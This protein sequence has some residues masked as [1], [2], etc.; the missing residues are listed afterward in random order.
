MQSEIVKWL[1]QKTELFSPLSCLQ[2]NYA[3][4]T[5]KT[6]KNTGLKSK[7][8]VFELKGHLSSNMLFKT[9]SIQRNKLTH[10]L[11]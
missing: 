5:V 6:I 3:V 10:G 4:D 1:P 7:F 11:Y 2:Y 8:E 9:S